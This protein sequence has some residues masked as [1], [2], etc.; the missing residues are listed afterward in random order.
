MPRFF[1]HS[2]DRV[3]LFE[4]REGSEWPD[5]DAARSEALASARELLAEQLKT[6]QTDGIEQLEICDASGHMLATVPLR[7]V[8][9]FAF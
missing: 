4:D 5:F 6:N 3:G 1:I 9:K 8:L 2:R 7:D